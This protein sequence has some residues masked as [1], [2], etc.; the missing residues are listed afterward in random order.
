M[1]GDM[2]KSAET[3]NRNLSDLDAFVDRCVDGMSK[4][5]LKTFEKQAKQIMNDAEARASAS[6]APPEKG[7]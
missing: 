6:G 7:K 5:E 2:S 3:S 4:R 1:E